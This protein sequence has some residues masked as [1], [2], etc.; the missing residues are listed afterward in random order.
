MIYYLFRIRFLGIIY[1]KEYQI[2]IMIV[3][4]ILFI[5]NPDI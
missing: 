4:N 5:D 2:V 3:S 1:N